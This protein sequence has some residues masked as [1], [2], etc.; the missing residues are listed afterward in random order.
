[1]ASGGSFSK[2]SHEFQTITS[3]GEDIIYI[4]EN[5]KLAINKEI[6]QEHSK[7]PECGKASFSE[8]KAI[9]TGNIFK[10]GTKYTKPFDFNFTDKDGSKKLVEMGCYGMGPSRLM[11]AIAEIHNDA[12]GIIWPEE[13]A[14]YQIHLIQVGNDAKISKQ[15][16]KIYQDLKKQGIQVLYDDRQDKA[17]GEKFADAD[18]IGIPVRIVVSKRTLEK[19]SVEIKQR[20]KNNITLVKTKKLSQFLR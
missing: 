9:E 15:T 18:L 16:E 14:P 1:L 4:C 17:P 6:K 13:V 20:N 3:A 19:D 7:C 11:G 5:C 12:N 8:E 2:Y 10:L